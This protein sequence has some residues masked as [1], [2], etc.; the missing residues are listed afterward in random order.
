MTGL[1]SSSYRSPNILELFKNINLG[2]GITEKGDPNLKSERSLY[3]EYGLHYEG[4]TF[5]AN[6]ALYSN[7]IDDYIQSSR[8]SS[9]LYRMDNVGKAEIM[10]VEQ[11]MEWDF[12]EGFTAY[13]NIAYARGKNDTTHEPLRF[14]APLNGLAGL[15][16]R[17]E[18]GFWWAFEGRWAAS[19]DNTPSGVNHSDAW[20]VLNARAGYGFMLGGLRNEI[21][22]GIDNILDK[23]YH[24]YLATSRGIELMEP[25]LNAYATWR[26][27]F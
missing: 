4:E 17:M 6:T 15:R 1:A 24:N 19:M 13:G 16:Q 27:K 7:S 5:R 3:F 20:L 21:V 9:S 18:S 25:G 12:Y 8:V 2:G 26:V 10:G 22:A 23:A 14:I 11:D